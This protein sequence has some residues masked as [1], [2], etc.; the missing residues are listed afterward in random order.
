[1]LELGSEEAGG[2]QIGATDLGMVRVFVHSHAGVL[3]LDYA[4]EEAEDIAEE[5]VAAA[6]QARSAATKGRKRN[7]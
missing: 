2:L 6:N 7:K 3:E 4:P 5:L 1:M